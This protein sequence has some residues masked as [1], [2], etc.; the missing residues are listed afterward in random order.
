[1]IN[2]KTE[3]FFFFFRYMKILALFKREHQKGKLHAHQARKFDKEEFRGG[4]R[5]KFW[6]FWLFLWFF[7][8]KCYFYYCENI[9]RCRIK[10]VAGK[11]NLCL[12]VSDG[13]MTWY[14]LGTDSGRVWHVSFIKPVSQQSLAAQERLTQEH[15]TP[16]SWLILSS[17]LVPWLSLSQAIL[18]QYLILFTQAYSSGPDSWLM[19]SGPTWV[20][21]K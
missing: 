12:Y 6:K 21:Q 9:N 8:F 17:S 18:L 16:C 15:T 20:M 11:W 19:T 4:Q 13:F 2:G 5:L 10:I 3:V 14:K 1:M 7:L